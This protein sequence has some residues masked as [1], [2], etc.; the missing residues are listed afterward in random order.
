MPKTM[1]AAVLHVP[2]EIKIEEREIPQIKDDEVLIKVK[3]VGVCGSDVHYYEHGRIGDFVVKKPLILG[4][5]AAGIIAKV[6]KQ[7]TDF[8]EGERVCIEPGVP[9]RKCEYCK[10]G[11]YNLCRDVV[12]LATPP[13]DG[14]FTEFL[15]HPADFVYKIPDSMSFA[16]GALIEPL[17]VGLHA[18]RRGNVCSGSTVCVLGAGTIGISSI[19]SAKASGATTIIAVDLENYRLEM[20][21][22]LGATDTINA[23][24]NDV[25]KA[26][27]DLTHGK[28]VDVVMEAAGAVPTTQQTVLLAK[29]GGVSVWIG[30][31]PTDRIPI[32]I[33]KAITKEIDI[34]PIFRYANVYPLAVELAAL[35][36]VNL[37]PMISAEFTLEKTKEALEYPSQNAATCIK[38]MVRFEEEIR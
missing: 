2:Q 29:P 33:H 26:V 31:A 36:L 37:K 38:V 22:K 27:M 35:G 14:A 5:E 11:R 4:H 13:V 28:G 17:S 32:S 1:K 34:R 15:A 7:V 18:T 6:G 20:A 3:A 23:K 19:Q 8:E 16:E 10:I 30:M 24:E 12:F 21:Q 25:V 9:C